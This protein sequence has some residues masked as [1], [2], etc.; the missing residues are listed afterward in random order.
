MIIMKTV[1]KKNIY[2]QSIQAS[3]IWESN[4]RNNRPIGKEEFVGMIPFSLES[5]H[6]LETGM[7][8]VS[9]SKKKQVS[10]DIVNVK[11][12]NGVRSGE[13]ILEDLPKWIELKQKSITKVA[14]KLHNEK[15]VKK[16]DSLKEKLNNLISELDSLNELQNELQTTNDSIWDKMIVDDL[17]KYLYTNGFNLN[18]YDKKAK[19]YVNVNFK[20]YKRSSSKSRKGE[21]WFIR[22]DL[23]KKMMKWSNM[24]L[25][26]DKPETDLAGLMAYES[27]VSSS[28]ESLIEIDP[29][30]ILCVDKV[31]SKFSRTVNVV[32]LKDG[33]LECKPKSHPIENEVF[34]GQA[35]LDSSMFKG[36][37]SKA[38]FVLLRQHFFKAACFNTDIQGFLKDYA[39]E[40][41]EN[42]DEWTIPDMF[43]NEIKASAIKLIVNPSCLKALKY[44]YAVKGGTKSAMW[45]H[46]KAIVGKD[47]NL[48]GICKHEKKT[49]R[50]DTD[51]EFPLQQLSYQMVNSLPCDEETITNLAS[52]ENN[53]I[54]QLK[55]CPEKFMLYL[56]RTKNSM[57]ANEMFIDIYKINPEIVESAI[58]RDFK[59]EIIRKYRE[60]LQSGK[61]RVKGDYCVMLSSPITYL[62]RAIG[63]VGDEITE[64]LELKGNQIYTTLLGKGKVVGF[65]N[66]HVSPANI[67]L[68]ENIEPNEDV[69]KYHRYFEYFNLTD[70]IAVVNVVG[71]LLPDT[72]NGC[73]FDS[74][75]C[76][77]TSDSN[78]VKVCEDNKG[79]YLVPVNNI[80]LANSED[81]K[82]RL[83]NDFKAKVDCKLSLS[84]KRIGSITNLAQIACSLM[85]NESSKKYPNKKL[86]S[87]LL[88][89][90]N[91]LAVCSGLAID[92]AKREYALDLDEQIKVYKS[93]LRAM[94]KIIKV[95]DKD[96][97]G[98]IIEIEDENGEKIVKKKLVKAKPLFWKYVQKDKKGKKNKKERYT[99]KYNTPMDWLFKQM[100]D[101]ERA[102][103]TVNPKQLVE[104]LEKHSV[105]A[106][107]RRKRTNVEDLANESQHETNRIH[108]MYDD[109]ERN[110]ELD[111][112]LEKYNE[113]IRKIT[114][115]ENTMYALLKRI[116]DRT[117]GEEENKDK[118]G[119]AYANLR[120]MN[121][122]YQTHKEL[123]L[124]IFKEK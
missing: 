46:W 82:Y 21:C 96:K 62:F 104:V 28:L 78:L 58:F 74:D 4:N 105:K 89:I 17:R 114:V 38:G 103:P 14:D 55:N 109:E 51:D 124:S 113:K 123:F 37:L 84:Q 8:T 87:G 5:I 40:N 18:I 102:D 33:I 19:G 25:N 53:Y 2:I 122:L 88:E 86:I 85:W 61:I 54:K 66:P 99:V 110:I 45:D 50:V 44:T 117:E 65:R 60:H 7:K 76:L 22:E 108:A 112:T 90:V 69:N 12:D 20:F 79:K 63:K 92:G 57:N 43:G 70:N 111:D 52:P 42:F 6:L 27:L 56:N 41:G 31:V 121:H 3:D 106:A 10:Y 23:H 100:G 68:T 29:E 80:D 98:K 34:D 59:K 116:S 15:Q 73:D 83:T 11:F 36:E 9:K 47:S 26:F 95:A 75:T 64:S 97:D 24:G 13:D 101:I 94:L 118:D 71:T 120:I 81:V 32:G 16:I 107:D 1:E 35:L 91:S 48:F 119:N 72:L 93:I 39:D 115:D 49:K 77:F 67:L 30:S